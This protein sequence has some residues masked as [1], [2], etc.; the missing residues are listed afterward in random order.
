MAI[1]TNT[2]KRQVIEDII[3][4]LRDSA[5]NQYF[6]GIGRSEDW[7]DSDVAPTEVSSLRE[8]RDF[9]LSMQ[10]IKTIADISFVI[11][12][13]NWSSGAIYSPYKDNIAGYPTQPYYVMNDNNQVYIVI[14]SAKN[15][16]GT[17][18]TST[19]Q[20]TGNT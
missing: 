17:L 8:E 11:P 15:T 5:T 13:N 7:N 14:E 20:P 3:A 9:R 2:I 18:L 12:R 1:I 6:V 10:S 16:T 4:D 19:V